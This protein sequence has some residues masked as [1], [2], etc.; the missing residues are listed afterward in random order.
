MICGNRFSFNIHGKYKIR[1][2]IIFI[3]YV[4]LGGDYNGNT[5]GNSMRL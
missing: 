1:I 5:R 3:Y 4:K 2:Y